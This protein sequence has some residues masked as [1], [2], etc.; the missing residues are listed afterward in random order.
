MRGTVTAT[1]LTV[2]A[3]ASGVTARHTHLKADAGYFHQNGHLIED[4]ADTNT[5]ESYDHEQYLDRKSRSASTSTSTKSHSLRK[6]KGKGDSDDGNV[7]ELNIF[8][9]PHSHGSFPFTLPR[10]NSGVN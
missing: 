1:A 3:V 2:A 4:F 6:G 8:V 7:T 9:L 10:A 5:Q